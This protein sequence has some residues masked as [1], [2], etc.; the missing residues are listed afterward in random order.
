MVLYFTLS[1]KLFMFLYFTLWRKS[2]KSAFKAGLHWEPLPALCI[3]QGAYSSTLEA[4]YL[5][6][7]GC[8]SRAAA[9]HANTLGV[10]IFKA[11]STPA[12][13]EY[14]VALSFRYL[15]NPRV[16]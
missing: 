10:Y 12:R 11:P 3:E 4:L 8:G 14:T 7:L 6:S 2:D 9:R 16:L 15:K 1:C 13:E 5:Q